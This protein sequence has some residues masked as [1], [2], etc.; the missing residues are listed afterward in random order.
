[1]WRLLPSEREID[2]PEE[3]DH[4]PLAHGDRLEYDL[5]VERLAGEEAGLADVREIL[6]RLERNADRHLDGAGARRVDLEML[7]LDRSVERRGIGRRRGGVGQRLRLGRF[8]GAEADADAIH[9][10]GGVA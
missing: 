8:V 2:L 4:L 6:F 3:R 9:G 1:M 5:V 10:R 7:R